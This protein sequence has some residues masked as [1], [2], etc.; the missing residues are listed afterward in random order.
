MAAFIYTMIFDFVILSLMSIKLF[1]MTTTRTP[2]ML[3]KLVFKDGLIYFI[4]A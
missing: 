4:I 3:S 2:S 1:K